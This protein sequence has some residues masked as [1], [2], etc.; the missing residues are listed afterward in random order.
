MI[1]FRSVNERRKD[2]RLISNVPVKMH[3][4]GFDFNTETTNI[5]RSGAYC[6]V[7]KYIKPMTTLDIHLF[8]PPNDQEKS[9]IKKI[10][11][12][13]AVVRT[14]P[15]PGDNAYNI[16][17]FFN[18]ISTHDADAISEFISHRLKAE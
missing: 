13:G 8:L 12:R 3:R 18:D 11:C 5:S 16:A 14:E 9:S 6:R 7:N 4:D 2:P 15:V 17:I 10:F 1:S